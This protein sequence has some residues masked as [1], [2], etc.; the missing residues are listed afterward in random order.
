[1]L[2]PILIMSSMGLLFGLGLAFASNIFRV[3]LDPRI[4]RIIGVLPG[5]NCGA[6]GKAGCAGLA[7]AIAKGDASL[8]SCPA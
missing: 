7:E 1:M 2:V 6:C 4:E 5:V 3:G 8:T